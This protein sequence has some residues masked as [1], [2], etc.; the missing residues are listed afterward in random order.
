MISAR[1]LATLL[2]ADDAPVEHA[3]LLL[4]RD[5]YPEL[6]VE[7]YLARLDALAEPLR[8]R[9]SRGQPALD[10]AAAIGAYVYDE[11][12]F[13]GNEQ[14]YYDPRNSFLNDVLDRRAGIPITLAV[15]L[16][17]LGRRAGIQVE[18]IGFPG[19][20]LVRVGGPSGLYVDPFFHARV[21]AEDELEELA[22]RVLGD[23][24]KLAPEHVAPVTTRQMVVRMLANLKGI[25]AGRKDHARGLLVCDRLV[26]LGVGPE[27]RRDRGLH[28][29]ALGSLETAAEDLGAYLATRPGAKDTA[30]V[31]AALARTK[32]RAILN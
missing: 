17:S 28:A 22:A 2:A 16:M 6:C 19:H 14:A 20:F 13:R 32:Q 18:G 5:E 11:L 10:Q 15:V 26:D 1:S 23:R 29:L 24:G 4:A 21:L 7:E 3:A 8:G 12:G 27:A 30:S 31:R 9:V 25:Y